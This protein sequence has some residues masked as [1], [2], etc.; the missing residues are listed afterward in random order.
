MKTSFKTEVSNIKNYLKKKL[1]KNIVKGIQKVRYAR[2]INRI[3]DNSITEFEIVKQLV[4]SGDTVV[5][6]GANM[7]IYT[8]LLSGL[9]GVNGKVYS[10]EPIPYTFDILTYIVTKLKLNQVTLYNYAISNF[11]GFLNMEIPRGE[12]GLE[13]YYTAKI[14]DSS[15]ESKYQ[16]VIVQTRTLEG[17]L[18]NEDK[19][20]F[21][22]LDVEGHEYE[23]LLGGANIIDKYKPSL[24]IEI[25]GDPDESN[26]A[27]HRTMKFLEDYGYRPF[28]YDDNK[29]RNR[30]LHETKNDYFFL[31]EE[32]ISILR[33]RSNLLT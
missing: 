23:C 9:V 30:K 25:W 8:K 32:H 22:K 21:I 13:N 3:S 20:S 7:G 12:N 1:N 28:I 19:I 11:D 26:S 29:L 10:I 14:I 6:V 24:F 16:T 5:D 2:S 33:Q 27:A 18:S 15:W 31:T 4:K 17:V